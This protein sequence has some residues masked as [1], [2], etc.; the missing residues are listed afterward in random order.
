MGGGSRIAKAKKAAETDN[1][2]TMFDKL[3]AQGRGRMS[4]AQK[5]RTQGPQ[6]EARM[7]SQT[8]LAYA[9]ALVNT[10]RKLTPAQKRNQA[11]AK[12]LVA[13]YEEKY[14]KLRKKPKAKKGKS[15]KGATAKKKVAK[16]KTTKRKT[17]KKK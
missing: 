2:K 5:K 14:P 9:R 8:Q 16:K 6:G 17:A 1:A 11:L 10:K 7:I 15:A 12:N 3:T 13:A 4:K